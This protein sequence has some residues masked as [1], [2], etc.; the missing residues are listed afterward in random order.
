MAGGPL[1]RLEEG[2]IVALVWGGFYCLGAGI[3]VWGGVGDSSWLFDRGVL[4]PQLL[5]FF[6]GD[7]HAVS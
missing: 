6:G 2:E 4:A 7:W 5:L 1:I 3:Q